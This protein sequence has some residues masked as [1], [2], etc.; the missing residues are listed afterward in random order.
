MTFVLGTSS[1]SKERDTK[2]KI[3]SKSVARKV[4][5]ELE[6]RRQALASFIK[7]KKYLKQYIIYRDV[8]DVLKVNGFL[9]ASLAKITD[10]AVGTWW[11]L[12]KAQ[13]HQADAKDKNK[14][15]LDKFYNFSDPS[16]SNIKDFYGMSQK[17]AYAALSLKFF[18]QAAFYILR[19]E[20]TEQPV[21]FDYIAGFVM[22]NI[23]ETGKF[24]S[25]AFIQ[26]AE[27]G[28]TVEY[29]ADEIVFITRPAV[30]GVATGDILVDALTK[31]S[32][33]L[34]LYL[35][36]SALKYIENGRLPPS[37]W[38]LPENISDEGFDALA[39]YIAQ[40]YTGA[41]NVGKSP[42]VVSGTL[43]V[44]R[45]GSFPDDIPYLEARSSSREEAFTLVGTPS[46]KLGITENIQGAVLEEIR[47][48]FHEST[49]RPLFTYLE[50]GFFKQIHQRL[51]NVEDWIFKFNAPDFLDSV[52]RATVHMRY[53]Q[54][55]VLNANEIR[56]E[57]GK[58]ERADGGGE[59]YTDPKSDAPNNEQ[60][61]PPE[62][63]EDEPDAPEETGEPTL[64][65]QDPPRGDREVGNVK[66]VL[67]EITL[68]KRFIDN[69]WDNLEQRRDFNF[70]FIKEDLQEVLRTISESAPGIA[71][72]REE[73][74]LLK[75][76]IIVWSKK[77][78]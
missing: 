66:E 16:W 44:K 68:Y 3:I 65:D 2:L 30:D 61:S 26:I 78:N 36:A 64:D 63:R 20:K 69:R 31:F 10:S 62:G 50:E 35:Q 29:E 45:V 39:D 60:G 75:E 67:N 59:F 21:G 33:P 43:N 48:E 6:Y 71:A 8:V 22:P 23:D 73:I 11:T 13:E 41:A 27:T 7:S 40:E 51:F 32:L 74:N 76:M 47:K 15:K 70:E 46:A 28:K 54:I 38:E 14:K 24:K 25:P 1:V 57:L 49:M 17:I 12:A 77:E 52:Q 19:D 5:P 34:D 58:G 55:G 56:S 42:I 9:K 37:I 4:D 18:G 72:F 53:R